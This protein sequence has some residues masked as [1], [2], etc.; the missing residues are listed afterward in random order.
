LHEKLKQTVAEALVREGFTTV[1]QEFRVR[2]DDKL[3][4]VDVAGFAEG[5]KIAVECNIRHPPSTAKIQAL[6][7]H[8]DEVREVAVEFLIDELERSHENDLTPEKRHAGA[9]LTGVSG[10]DWVL[11]EKMSQEIRKGKIQTWGT[12]LGIRLHLPC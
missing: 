9:L 3:F 2:V 11:I 8:F 4:I 6:A 1:I 7:R 12:I 5:R 10:L